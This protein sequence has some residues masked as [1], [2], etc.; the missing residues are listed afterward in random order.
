MVA[1]G[2]RLCGR[3]PVYPVLGVMQKNAVLF[4]FVIKIIYIPSVM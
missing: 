4:A 2:R 3:K 1:R